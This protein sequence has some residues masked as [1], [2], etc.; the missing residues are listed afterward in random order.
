MNDFLI[1]E[2]E[3]KADPGTPTEDERKKLEKIYNYLR[4]SEIKMLF[5]LYPTLIL[6]ILTYFLDE[7]PLAIFLIVMYAIMM[8]VAIL[9]LMIK[10]GQ[11][12][13]CPRCSMKGVPSTSDLP[14]RGNCPGCGL[15]LDISDEKF[16]G[17]DIL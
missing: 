3:I 6:I 4:V 5:M 13:R 9:Y 11:I 8:L 7:Y 17:K 14:V 15:D 12:K 1:R 2:E 16:K 10:R